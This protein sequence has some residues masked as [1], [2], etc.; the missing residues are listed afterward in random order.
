[1]PYQ[2]ASHPRMPY[3]EKLCKQEIQSLLNL[4]L[5]RSSKFQWARPVFNGNKYSEQVQG[6]KRLVIDYRKLNEC[7]Q[8]IRYHIPR[9]T[10]FF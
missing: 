5:I 6:K 3:N 7:L 10:H 2:T 9:R 4:K 8:D 1:M